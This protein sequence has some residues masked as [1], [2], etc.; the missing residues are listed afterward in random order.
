MPTGVYA[1]Q[2]VSASPQF[3]APASG[4]ISPFKPTGLGYFNKYP[5]FAAAVG[6]ANASITNLAT[7]QSNDYLYKL[8][9]FVD[10]FE[11]SWSLSGETSQG[12]LSRIFYPRN[13]TQGQVQIEGSVANQYEYDRLVHFVEHHHYSQMRPQGAIAN[14]LDGNQYPSVD[15]MLFKPG[16]KQTFNAFSP[17]YYSLLILN[18]EA[19]HERFVNFPTYTL[20]CKVTYDYLEDRFKDT[21]TEDFTQQ[22]IFGASDAPVGDAATSTAGDTPPSAVTN[23]GGATK[24][25]L[26]SSGPT[27]PPPGPTG[28]VG[29]PSAPAGLTG[30][31][32]G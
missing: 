12:Q 4:N 5:D 6:N 19:G 2:K 27:A 28:P 3:N 21:R 16:N 23:S 8:W 13:M 11:T 17:V 14:T 29:Q 18:I 10:A 7:S 25:A 20:T 31:V 9:L 26:P 22:A 15:F 32:G 24:Q 30:P 1:K